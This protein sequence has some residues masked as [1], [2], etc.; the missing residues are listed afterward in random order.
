M[1]RGNGPAWQHEVDDLVASLVAGMRGDGLV[2]GE[3]IELLA[4][5]HGVDAE[6]LAQSSVPLVHALVRHG[7]V[8]PA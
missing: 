8:L 1:H 7:L 4:A 5:A 6:E 3:L 2:L